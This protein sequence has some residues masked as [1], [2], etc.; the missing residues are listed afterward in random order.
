MPAAALLA[1][2]GVSQPTL[3]RWVKAL[4]PMVEAI[5]QTRSRKYALRRSVR[6]VGQ[7]WPLHRIDEHGRA[8]QVGTMRALH[9]GFRVLPEGE[10]W[11]Q[12]EYPEGVFRGLP[13]FLQDVAPAGYLGRA[14]ARRA[15]E[16][17]A[18][19]EDPRR[20]SDDDIL[21]YLLA[22]GSELPGDYVLGDRALE[23]ALRQQAETR[24]VPVPE[25]ERAAAYPA[26]AAAAQRGELVGSS[27]SGEQPKFL[28]TLR[29][30]GGT[31]AA[32]VKFSSADQSPVQQRWM[33]LLRC[34]QIAA[35]V[36]AG[37]GFAAV[38]ASTLDAGG[39]RFLEI[40][41]FDRVGVA[42]RRGALTLRA[43]E[44]GLLEESS[45]DWSEAAG[46]LERGGWITPA[47]GRELRW[48]WCF[49]DLIG[50]SDM[51]HH[52][53]SFSLTDGPPFSL[54][55]AYDMLPMMYAPGAQGELA[56]REF[57]PR[58]PMPVVAAVWAEAAAAAIQFWARAAEDAMVS[59]GFRAT[60]TGNGKTL[61]NRRQLWG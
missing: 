33:D 59:E 44:E 57:A 60:A 2:L 13:F 4:G 54:T 43:L 49:G 25:E 19:P 23:R 10:T 6:H 30:D 39:R 14:V 27:A 56:E 5:G 51:H 52:N 24:N 38:R 21:I 9:G 12:R 31:A 11:W 28:V 15:A 45:A 58:P 26:L 46:R 36:I 53:A 7:E 20:W 18:V 37:H 34:E 3:S 55:P 61:A 40:E 41:R 42:G 22:E 8:R 1:D 16:P 47:A 48:L 35:E 17:L 32:M 50:N 29:R